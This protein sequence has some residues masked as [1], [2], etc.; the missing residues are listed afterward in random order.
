MAT[1]LQHRHPEVPF[2]QVGDDTITAL[3]QLEAIFKNKFQKPK[4]PDLTHALLI[5]QVRPTHKYPIS[6]WE[7]IHPPG[8]D[9]TVCM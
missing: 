2:A 4:S 3:T 5:P 9:N 8:G 1:T 7:M 6:P